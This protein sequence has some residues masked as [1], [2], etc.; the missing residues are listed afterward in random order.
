M[1]LGDGTGPLRQALAAGLPKLS[2]TE[3]EDRAKL[4]DALNLRRDSVLDLT[5]VRPDG[6][7]PPS[8]V[9]DRPQEEFCPT[10][11][12][13]CQPC[14]LA[15]MGEFQLPKPLSIVFLDL[16]FCRGFDA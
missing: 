3:V 2:K 8:S 11:G 6:L 9:G 7:P 16:M 4:T 5:G 12:T 13:I 1:A 10:I 15:R 14:G